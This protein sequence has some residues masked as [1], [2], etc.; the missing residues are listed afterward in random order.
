MAGPS[1]INTTNTPVY[2]Q[3]LPPA[4]APSSGGGDFG[5]VLGG[6]VSTGLS[7]MGGGGFGGFGGIGGLSSLNSTNQQ[8][9]LLKMQDEIQQRSARFQ[10]LSNISKSESDTRLNSIRNMKA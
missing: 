7:V 8:M 1:T 4:P 5:A 3:P 2:A 9:Q 6:L 10:T